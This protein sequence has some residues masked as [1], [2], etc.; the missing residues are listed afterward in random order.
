MDMPTA[1]RTVLAKYATFSGRATRPE[2]WWWVLATLIL[3]II[4][5]LLDGAVIAPMLGFQ[6]FE[7]SAGEPLSM[8]ASLALILPNLAVAV[9]RLH[10]TDRSGWWLLLSLVPVI[11]TLLLLYFL[12][13]QSTEGGNRF[14]DD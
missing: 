11:G 4:L 9:R 7:E 13:Q 8:I 1:V 6:M 12:V 3:F 2:Y 5:S 10:D 14:C